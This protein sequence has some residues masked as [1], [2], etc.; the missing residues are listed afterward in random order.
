M[1]ALDDRTCLLRPLRKVIGE[2]DVPKCRVGISLFYVGT[3][4]IKRKG[5]Y[6]NY[7]KTMYIIKFIN[8]TLNV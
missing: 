3:L 4:N 8:F 1:L 5:H 6:V 7:R 2:I